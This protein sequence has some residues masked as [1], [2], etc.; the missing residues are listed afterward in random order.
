MAIKLLIL[1][2]MMN[3]L[4][5]VFFGCGHHHTTFPLTSSR[6]AGSVAAPTTNNTYVVCLDCGREF[7]YDWQTMR[8]GQPV[9]VRPEA[10]TVVPSGSNGRV[11]SLLGRA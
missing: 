4:I 2:V 3:A 6:K 1:P 8:I 5:N 10:V 7:Q 11:T 9:P